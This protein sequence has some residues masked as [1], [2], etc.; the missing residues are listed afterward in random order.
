MLPCPFDP[1][2]RTEPPPHVTTTPSTTA[3]VDRDDDGGEWMATDDNPEERAAGD[4]AVELEG[5][6][7]L[8]SPLLNAAAAAAVN[9]W[10][11][12][13][14]SSMHSEKAD[15]ETFGQ[16]RTTMV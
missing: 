14:G 1:W 7:S 5:Y 3:A 12:G 13:R 2:A 4:E 6:S 16:I 15:G 9:V 10:A 8:M 11:E